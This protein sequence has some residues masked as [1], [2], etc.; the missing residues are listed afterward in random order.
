MFD[1]F[2][3]LN[4]LIDGCLLLGFFYYLRKVE[5][6][7]K[8]LL[9]REMALEVEIDSLRRDRHSHIGTICRSFYSFRDLYKSHPHLF[10]SE[11]CEAAKVAAK[12]SYDIDGL[13]G[14]EFIKLMDARI[15]TNKIRAALEEQD[16]YKEVSEEQVLE[17]L[18]K[19]NKQ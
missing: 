7:Y 14:L 4:Y 3:T 12:A 19:M 5:K 13:E 6:A 8:K 16:S 15:L 10:C 2:F 9:E 17:L 18:E 1:T 11:L